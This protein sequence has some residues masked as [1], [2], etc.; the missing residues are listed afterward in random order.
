MKT[1]ITSVTA[2]LISALMLVQFGVNAQQSLQIQKL[3][4]KGSKALSKSFNS[5]NQQFN[6][7]PKA[8]KASSPKTLVAPIFTEDFAVGIPGTWSNIDNLPPGGL[9]QTGFSTADATTLSSP[10]GANGFVFFDSDGFGDDFNAENADLITPM[11]DA[12]ALPSVSLTFS[13]YF[14]AGFGGAAEVFVSNNGGTTYTSVASWFASSTANGQLESIDI[15]SIAA[16]N[17]SIVIKFN[18]TGDYSWYWLIDDIVVDINLNNE[19]VLNSIFSTSYSLIPLTQAFP[20]TFEGRVDNTGVNSQPNVTLNATV[21]GAGTFS[22]NSAPL[23][24]LPGVDSLL[25]VTTTYTPS[26]IGSYAVNFTVSSDSVDENPANDT[27]SSAFGVSDTVFARDNGNYTGNGVWFGPGSAFAF[28]IA[29]EIVDTQEVRSISVFLQGST[30]A[31]GTL[32]AKLYDVSLTTVIDSSVV[33]TIQ[34]GDI[35]TGFIPLSL[36]NKPILTPGIYYA[37]VASLNGASDV[38]FATGTDYNQPTGSVMALPPGGPPWGTSSFTPFIRLNFAP[39]LSA[40]ITDSADATCNNA[41]GPCDGWA[42]VAAMDGTPTYT[43]L[44]S[45]GQTTD[46]AVGLCAGAHTVWVWDAAGDSALATVTINQPTAITAV[47]SSTNDTTGAGVGTASVLAGGGTPPYTY[48]WNTGDTTTTIDSIP[49]GT[50]TVD[51]TDINGCT[52]SDSVLVNVGTVSVSITFITDVTCNGF[53]DGEAAVSVL[54]GTGPFT[55]LWDDSTTQ[56]NDTA[57]GLCAGTYTVWIWDSAG[58]DSAAVFVTINE[59]PLFIISITPGGSTTLCGDSV[60]LVSDPAT[61]YDWLLNNVPTGVTG[62]N[63]YA[64]TSGDYNVVATNASGCVDTSATVTV[65][66]NLLPVIAVAPGSVCGSNGDSVTLTASGA[67]SYTWSPSASLSAATG[68][69]VSAFPTVNTTYTVVGTDTNGCID[70]TTV[71]VQID[72]TLCPVGV[73]E[74]FDAANSIRFYPNPTTGIINIDV[75]NELKVRSIKVYNIIGNLVLDLTNNSGL[76]KNQ[77]A[78]ELSNYPSGAYII[79][80]ETDDRVITTKVGLNTGK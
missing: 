48:S 18:F 64:S 2:L 47:M 77:F 60:E 17:D 53:C 6:V 45:D 65:T 39:P 30:V 29:F 27:L 70:A 40:A 31:G 78:I 51:V 10:T 41:N 15:S 28:A 38:I 67:V 3:Q 35:A 56:T 20:I 32:K 8:V 34:A 1:K 62:I 9:W 63:Y 61:T 13:H 52:F 75:G 12:S 5:A 54:S 21:T 24:L 58:T 26:T 69:V 55:Y 68:A 50:Y 57:T 23:T 72:T 76:T 4:L 80:V 74:L 71:L 49:G 7:S 44:W 22:G 16:G 36:L 73:S 19:L 59:P 33:F 11:I 43:Y 66:V 42:V 14:R 46:S 79:K 25:T 37:S